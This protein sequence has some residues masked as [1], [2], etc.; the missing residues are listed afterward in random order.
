MEQATTCIIINM[1]G[2]GAQSFNGIAEWAHVKEN[3]KRVSYKKKSK[4]NL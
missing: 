2:H 4:R 1:M 3:D